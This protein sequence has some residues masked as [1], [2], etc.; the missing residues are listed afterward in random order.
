MSGRCSKGVRERPNHLHQVEA[1]VR[2]CLNQY[3]RGYVHR[4]YVRRDD[5]DRVGAHGHDRDRPGGHCRVDVRDHLLNLNP[6]DAVYV[7]MDPICNAILW[8]HRSIC[9]CMALPF[10]KRKRIVNN[11][12]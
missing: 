7:S 8:H 6:S 11:K 4:V 5:H 9:H 12:G 3:H 10:P 2:L 1:G